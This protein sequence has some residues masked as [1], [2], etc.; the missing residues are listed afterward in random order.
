MLK[1]IVK[2]ETRHCE[3]PLENVNES[4]PIFAKRGGKLRGM[5]IHEDR[6]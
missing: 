5:I 1:V 4:T 6:G 2:E 3:I